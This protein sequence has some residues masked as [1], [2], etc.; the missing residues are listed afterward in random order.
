MMNE[1]STFAK[2]R[3]KFRAAILH[4]TDL[5][6]GARI[7]GYEIAD[8]IHVRSI[9]A[10][11]S[12][13]WLAQQLGIGI[14]TVRRAVA[15]LV[16]A[17]WF[18]VEMDGRSW[19]YVPSEIRWQNGGRKAAK[20][21]SVETGLE[22]SEDGQ[23]GLSTAA[24]MVPLS[25]ISTQ[26][27][28]DPQL[29]AQLIGNAAA[30]SLQRLSGEQDD[31][32]HG[33]LSGVALAALAKKQGAPKFVF[34]DSKPWKAWLDYRKRNGLPAR[35]PT[36]QHIIGGRARTGWH[37]PTLWPPGYGPKNTDNEDGAT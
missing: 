6:M 29:G 23:V 36:G 8:L 5:G 2:Q 25:S 31:M 21:A 10:W 4:D 14:R 26:T 34:E 27:D 1:R 13:E 11:P 32:H 22:C 17:E 28:T 24:K 20:L 12:Q 9:D 19:R 7:V 30:C 18:T 33:A 16:K 3:A 37:M 15:E 35:L